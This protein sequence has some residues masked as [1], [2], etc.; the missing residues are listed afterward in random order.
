MMAV[1]KEKLTRG[2]LLSLTGLVIVLGFFGVIHTQAGQQIPFV[3]ELAAWIGYDLPHGDISATQMDHFRTQAVLHLKGDQNAPHRPALGLNLDSTTIRQTADW[4]QTKGLKCLH[5]VSGYA[6]IQCKN[7][8]SASLGL[9]N[10]SQAN[11]LI[12]EV[13]F[14][15]NSGGKLIAVNLL[16]RK[17]SASAGVDLISVISQALKNSLGV[18]TKIIG[19]NDIS[20][21][22]KA[23]NSVSI[24]YN[25]KDYLAKVTAS[26]LPWSGVVLYEQYMS[27]K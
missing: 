5:G 23:M 19:Q 18:P 24:E 12:D 3:R 15:F 9:N 8:P 2:V 1:L 22:A 10:D 11:V 26:Y 4:L 7:V 27:Y 21:F 6:F 25:F 13:D 14:S 17:L 16:R 20:T